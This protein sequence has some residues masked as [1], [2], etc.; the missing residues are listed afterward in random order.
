ME[1]TVNINSCADCRHRDH[2]RAF[3]PGGAILI[4]GHVDACI[5]YDSRYEACHWRQRILP[6]DKSIPDWCPLKSGSRY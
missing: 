5:Q 2:S 6:D 1:I 4:C 3:T